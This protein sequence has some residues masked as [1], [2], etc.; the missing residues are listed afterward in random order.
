[1]D[2]ISLLRTIF[3]TVGKSFDFLSKTQPTPEMSRQIYDDKRA[4][5]LTE[6]RIKIET[7]I[8]NKIKNVPDADIEKEV[9]YITDISEEETQ[10]LISNIQA[11]INKYR[12]VHPIISGW[13]RFKKR[14]AT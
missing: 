4:V 13:R 11:R 5:L 12:D 3:D 14:K 2:F 9:R 10:Q 7:K 6:Q 1:M 8:F